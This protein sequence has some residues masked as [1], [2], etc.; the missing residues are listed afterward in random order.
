MILELSFCTPIFFKTKMFVNV[1]VPIVGIISI[2][3]DYWL[4]VS[5]TYAPTYYIHL[6]NDLYC[7]YIIKGALNN[8]YLYYY[9]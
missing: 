4:M 8:Q 5:N 7:T 1:G 6:N 3:M 9:R 2:G